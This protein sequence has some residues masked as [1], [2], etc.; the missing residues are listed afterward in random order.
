MDEQHRKRIVRGIATIAL[1]KTNYDRGKDHIGMFMPFIIDALSVVSTNYFGIEDVQQSVKER[2]NLDIPR[3]TLQTLLSRACKQGFLTRER[4]M[5]SKVPDKIPQLTL[6]QDR[7]ALIR[8]HNFLAEALQQFAAGK[9]IPIASAEDALAMMWDFLELNHVAMLIENQPDELASTPAIN[10]QRIVASFLSDA[11]LRRPDITAIVQ[12][13]LE[14]YVLQNTLLLR[15]IAVAKRRF[16]NLSVYIDTGIIMSA[17]GYRGEATQKATHEAFRL[18]RD[19]GARL[20]VF[21]A[22]ISEVRRILCVYEDHLK[23]DFGRNSLYQT[24]VTRFFLTKHFNPS[25][26]RTELSLIDRNIRDIGLVV[27]SFPPHVPRYTLDEGALTKILARSDAPELERRVTHDVDCIAAILTLRRGVV[28][29]NLDDAHAIFVSSSGLPVRNISKWYRDEGQRGIPPIIHELALSNAAWLKH[30]AKTDLK[31]TQ[32]VALCSAALRPTRAM[33]QAFLNHLDALQKSGKLSSDEAIAF[34]A[35]ELTD[36]VL[37]E[38]EVAHGDDWEPTPETLGDIVD[39]VRARYKAESDVQIGTARE[40]QIKSEQYIAA[41]HGRLSLIADRIGSA[42]AWIVFGALTLVL[43]GGL[44]FSL[45]ALLIGQ[46]SRLTLPQ[47]IIL[48]LSSLLG[49][50]NVLFGFDAW[51]TRLKTKSRISQVA[52]KYLVG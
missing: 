20:A 11:L 23:S 18:L 5:L 31:L 29:S 21:E 3:H 39:R 25:D 43:I 19:T 10:R 49:V 34:V 45:K 30:P 51:S 14:G 22:T 27:E 15:D 7:D 12:R 38:A 24:D 4:G 13:M 28:Y 36:R 48:V 50:C 26:I 44:A 2:H 52:R 16:R 46:S 32:L 6:I 33:W 42:A 40:A 8:E 35:S 37:A 1:L 41:L 47:W 9:Q 17:L